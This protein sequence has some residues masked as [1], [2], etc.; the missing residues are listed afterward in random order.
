[1][2]N[3]KILHITTVHRNTDNRIFQKEVLGLKNAGFDISLIAQGDLDSKVNGI[4]IYAV[5]FSKN[6]FDRFVFTNFRILLRTIK[7]NP[8]ICHFHDPDF[9]FSAAILRMLGKKVI[10]DVHEDVPKQ[11]MSKY[12]IPKLLRNFIATLFNAIEKFLSYFFFH[13]VVT[14]TDS[15]SRRFSKDKVVVV[16]NYPRLDECKDIST[17]Y[18]NRENAI[19]YIGGISKIRGINEMIEAFLKL[20]TQNVKFYLAGP[21]DN[22]ELKNNILDKINS[23]PNIEYLGFLNRVEVARYLSQSRL[24]LVLFHPEPNHIEA[25]PN[26]IFEYMSAKLPVL[27]SNFDLWKSIIINNNCGLLVDPLDSDKIAESIDWVLN[28]QEK[29]QVF[30]ENG[31]NMVSTKFN[32]KVEENKLIGLYNKLLDRD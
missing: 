11:I 10:Y 26:K 20:K 9:I 8:Q 18:S 7:I 3:N 19:I 4:D 25:G 2:K 6:R 29:A 28:N 1:M 15:I 30:G 32:W 17:D 27:G 24:G 31:R 22:N 23:I 12:W 14:A 13:Y 16:H 21:F 5:P